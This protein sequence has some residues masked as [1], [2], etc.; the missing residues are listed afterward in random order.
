MGEEPEFM[1]EPTQPLPF[2]VNAA[3]EIQKE[4]GGS[5]PFTRNVLA[6]IITRHFTAPQEAMELAREAFK[7]W[8][9]VRN[10]L[11][12]RTTSAK[13]WDEALAALDKVLPK[14]ETEGKA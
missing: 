6:L 2:A 5:S 11:L 4:I 9:P 8:Q 14:K 12:S 3:E 7:A 13:K 1:S 10:Q